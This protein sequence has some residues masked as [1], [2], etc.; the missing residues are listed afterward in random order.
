MN[1]QKETRIQAINL[2]LKGIFKIKN[3]DG[4]SVKFIPNKA[5]ILVLEKIKTAWKAGKKARIIVIKGRQQGIS[6]VIQILQLALSI[7]VEGWNA[8]TMTHNLDLAKDLFENKIKYAYD[9]LPEDLKNLLGASKNNVRQLM[10]S[11]RDKSAITVGT[12]GRG[13][14]YQSIHISEAGMMS[15]STETWNE[16]IAGTLESGSGADLIIHESTADGGLGLF[17]E[18][19]NDNIDD[20]LF[21]SWTLQDEYQEEPPSGDVSWYKE[22]KTLASDFKLCQ[23]PSDEFNLTNQ[24]F[25]WYYKKAKQLKEAIK[26]QYP[27][28]LQEAFQSTAGCYFNLEIIKK[29]QARIADISS[30]E[31]HNFKIYQQP[32][33]GRKYA[34]GVDTSTGE[35]NDNTSI[36]VFC[37]Q[38]LEQVACSTGSYSEEITARMTVLI[39]NH[40]N[41]AVI[42]VE[43]N[44]MGRAVQNFIERFEYPDDLIFKRFEVDSTSPRLARIPKNGWLT[45]SATRPIMLSEFKSAFEDYHLLLNDKETLDEMSTFVNIK[46]KYQAQNGKKDDRVMSC[47]IAYQCI[48]Y[49]REY[50]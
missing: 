49:V 24:Q 17:Y 3:K 1:N 23:D 47:M 25:Y 39:A 50:C 29:A 34:V 6:T 21:L 40:Y 18:Y 20:V 11:K 14:T 44:N 41:Q 32:I 9:K 26:V 37:V 43:I 38:T 15:L 10:F 28:S 7:T 30:Q 48:K 2:I 46:G 8:Y 27:L 31:I 22:Y 35:S 45:S 16:M 13:G 42:G 12:S 4:K 5:Q 33:K 36:N 19:V